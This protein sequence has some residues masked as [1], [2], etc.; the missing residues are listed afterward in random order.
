MHS[1][2]QTLACTVLAFS[3]STAPSVSAADESVAR[4]AQW[5]KAGNRQAQKAQRRQRE[6]RLLWEYERRRSAAHAR[7]PNTLHASMPTLRARGDLS[8]PVLA[9]E[10]TWRLYRGQYD[11]RGGGRSALEAYRSDSRGAGITV[12][13]AAR[14]S[15]GVSSWGSS[16]S[17]PGAK[18]S[19]RIQTSGWTAAFAQRKSGTATTHHVYLVPSA[20]EPLR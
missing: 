10:E 9:D 4:S 17:T 1:I 8:C 18:E 12:Y 20:S 2:V 11:W 13:P 3:A 15:D 5:V 16:S 7:M 14:Q 6:A 19:R